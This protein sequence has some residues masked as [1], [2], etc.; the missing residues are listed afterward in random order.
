MKHR[1]TSIPSAGFEPAT[2][3]IERLQTSALDRTATGICLKDTQFRQF[4][5][6]NTSKPSAPVSV[7]RYFSFFRLYQH[8]EQNIIDD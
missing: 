7:H 8:L 5:S 4:I 6:L 3:R 1:R 2:P